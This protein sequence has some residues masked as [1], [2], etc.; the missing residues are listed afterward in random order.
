MRLSK[1][2]TFTFQLIDIN[3]NVQMYIHTLYIHIQSELQ[4]CK[5]EILIEYLI[6]FYNAPDVGY[7]NENFT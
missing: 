6:F 7:T 3:Q 1:K 5:S 2:F 4:E